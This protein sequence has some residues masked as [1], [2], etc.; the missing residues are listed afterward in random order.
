MRKTIKKW[1]WVWDFDK[2]EKWLNEMS[3]KGLAL[4]SVNGI[5]YTFEESIPSG[6]NV[7]LEMLEKS[8]SHFESEIYIKFLEETGAEYLGSV[9]RWV[10]FRQKAENGEFNLYSD[11]ATRVKHLNRILSLIGVIF[12]IQIVNGLNN[13]FIYSI[14]DIVFN[15]LG[16]LICFS[17]AL[18]L[19]YGF[20]RINKKKILIKKEQQLFE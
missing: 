2:Q 9:Q 20:L 3:A 12:F 7:R 10:Y 5:K 8:P 1:F 18:L 15:L 19:G 14:N 16:S 17:L 13:L 4:V 11:K 6:Y